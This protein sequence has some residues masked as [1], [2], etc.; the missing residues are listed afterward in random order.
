MPT[1]VIDMSVTNGDPGDEEA[2]EET[3]VQTKVDETQKGSLKENV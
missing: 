3:K 1:K 2:L